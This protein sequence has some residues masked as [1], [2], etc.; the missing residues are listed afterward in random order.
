MAKGLINLNSLINQLIL[1][2]YRVKKFNC[3]PPENRT[4]LRSSYSESYISSPIYPITAN[5]TIVI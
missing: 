3:E 1:L 2:T 4:N 5:P